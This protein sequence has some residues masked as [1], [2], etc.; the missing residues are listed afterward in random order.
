MRGKKFNGCSVTAKIKRALAKSRMM[1]Q[2]M[3]VK[4]IYIWLI[5]LSL[6]CIETQH[7]SSLSIKFSFSRKNH[8]PNKTPLHALYK[9]QVCTS[10]T[11]DVNVSFY[12]G[13]NILFFL[14]LRKKI[15]FV[16]A[17]EFKEKQRFVY[18]LLIKSLFFF[19]NVLLCFIV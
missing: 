14:S 5:F 1:F 7:L 8:S 3:H 19:L 2:L 15:N 13:T 16:L 6:I 17:F 9:L 18:C 10:T 11:R 12:L 4:L